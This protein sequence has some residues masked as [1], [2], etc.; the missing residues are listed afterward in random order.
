M[1]DATRG[2]GSGKRIVDVMDGMDL[3]DVMD[4]EEKKTRYGIA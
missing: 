3:M 1:R 2:A 4:R